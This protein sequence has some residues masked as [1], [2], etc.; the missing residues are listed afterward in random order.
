[1]GDV[2][3]PTP[4]D[5]VVPPLPVSI[6]TKWFDDSVKTSTNM[7]SSTVFP[8]WVG[9]MHSAKIT[10]KAGRIIIKRIIRVHKHTDYL[11]TSTVI[12]YQ[13]RILIDGVEYALIEK[14]FDSTGVSTACGNWS[15]TS[16]ETEVEISIEAGDHEIIEQGRSA[17]VSGGGG[18]ADSTY[19]ELV[20]DL[21]EIREA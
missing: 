20:S 10:T 2:L 21:L 11:S 3:V 9:T 19:N 18:D 8:S 6:I 13:N 5:V 4:A 17:F 16:Y 1:M 14:N 15:P 12:A 7:S